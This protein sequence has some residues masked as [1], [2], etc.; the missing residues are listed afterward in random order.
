MPCQRRDKRKEQKAETEASGK[1]SERA[2]APWA[3]ELRP[4]RPGLGELGF[5]P[6]HSSFPTYKMALRS[7]LSSS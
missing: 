6:L 4:G 1:G 2:L 7:A 3:L 5:P